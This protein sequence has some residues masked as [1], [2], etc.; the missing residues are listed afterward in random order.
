MKHQQ[1]LE[2]KVTSFD[3][4]KDIKNTRVLIRNMNT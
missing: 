3:L 2:W 1:K 4:V